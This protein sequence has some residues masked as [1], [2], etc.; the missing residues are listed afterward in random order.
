MFVKSRMHVKDIAT[1]HVHTNTTKANVDNRHTNIDFD[2]QSKSTFNVA[3]SS[4]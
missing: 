1:P 3:E 2:S 4:R